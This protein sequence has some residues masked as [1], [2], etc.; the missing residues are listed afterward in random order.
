MSSPNFSQ[1]LRHLQAQLTVCLDCRLAHLKDAK[2]YP[3]KSPEKQL[4]MEQANIQANQARLI[5]S[6]IRL[7]KV[8]TEATKESDHALVA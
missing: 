8:I 3:E 1:D 6:Y 2:K 5:L 4:H 7:K